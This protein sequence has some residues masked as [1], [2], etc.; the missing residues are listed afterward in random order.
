ME[1]AKKNGRRLES[2]DC[3]IVAT[4]GHRG[5]PLLTHDRDMVG[6]SIPGLQ[7]VTYLE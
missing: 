3:W 1:E 2:G 5:I 7:V 6:H 4:A